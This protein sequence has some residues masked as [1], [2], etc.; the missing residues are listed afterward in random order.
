MLGLFCLLHLNWSLKFK[1]ELGGKFEF[2]I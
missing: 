2:K 1:T